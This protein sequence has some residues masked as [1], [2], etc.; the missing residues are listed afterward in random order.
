M[1]APTYLEWQDETLLGFGKDAPTA[2][3]IP[4]PSLDTA[5]E[6]GPS[7]FQ[8][9]LNGSW[10]FHWVNHPDRRPANFY[11]T[12]FNDSAWPEIRVPSNWQTEGYDV[13]VY[14]NQRYPFLCQPPLV[15]E[16]PPDHYTTFYDRNPVGSYRRTFTVPS[17][18]I[19]RRICVRFEGVD[20]FF[21][22]WINGQYVGF[23]KD[24]RTTAAFDLTPHLVEGENQI[25][26][27]VYRYSDGSYLEDQ[28]FWRLSGIYR[29]V[30]L[31]AHAPEGIRDFLIEPRLDSDLQGG[32]LNVTCEVP[33]DARLAIH[34]FDAEANLVKTGAASD[35]IAE[36]TVEAPRLWSA[37]IP[38]LYVVVL[39]LTDAAGGVI[40]CASTRCGFRRIEIQDGVFWLNNVAIKL[41]G[42]NRHEHTYRDGHA[43]SVESM[44]EDIRLMKQ[45]NINHVRTAHY[46][47]HPAWYDL[48]DEYGLYVMDE[49]NVESHGCGYEEK[50]LSHFPSWRAAH[51]ERCTNM[52]YRDRNHPCV[53]FWSLGNEAGPGENFQH[54]ADAVRALDPTRPL[55]YE[56]ANWVADIDSIMY[57]H[58]EW[59]EDEAAGPRNRP[60]YL[61]EYGHSMGNAVGNLHNYWQ[62]IESSPHMLGGCIWEWM[63]HALPARTPEGAEYPAYGG[64]FGDQPNDGLFIADGLLFYDRSPKPAY[65]ELKKVHQPIRLSWSPDHPARV[66]VCN[67]HDFTDLENF[68]IRWEMI[69][70]GKTS[71]FGEWM[72]LSLAPCES[73][74]IEF[75]LRP[76]P[77]TQDAWL[78]LRVCLREDTPWAE[79]NFEIAAEQLFFTSQKASP[80]SRRP[81][82]SPPKGKSSLQLEESLKDWLIA[83]KDF[84]V[85]IGKSAEPTFQWQVEGH[86]LMDR[87]PGLNAFR[88]PLDNDWRWIGDSWFVHGLHNLNPCIVESTVESVASDV[89]SLSTKIYWAANQGARVESAVR[90]GRVRLVSQPIPTETLRFSTLMRWQIRN[91]CTI[92]LTC[93]ITPAGLSIVLPRLGLLF[94]LPTAWDQVR[95]LGRGPWENYPDRKSAAFV[96]VNELTVKE[97]LTPYAKPQDCGSR[98]DVRWLEIFSRG[99]E[100]LHITCRTPLAA[101]ALPHSP[102]ELTVA[103]HP[104]ELPAPERTWLSLDARQLGIGG[105]S[106]GPPPHEIDWVRPDPVTLDLTM[107]PRH[108]SH[109]P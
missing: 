107:K 39:V 9:S 61:C 24:S 6:R 30:F 59:M 72:D 48:C 65:W 57:A 62:P 69:E 79:A 97:M 76:D 103:S 89:I 45:A 106:C 42:V 105:N 60:F 10:K 52:V 93:Q 34:L 46:P 2:S 14:T 63:D 94:S 33:Q 28:D 29:D 104:H 7:P 15:M 84:E 31:V 41:R 91:D 4:Y 99:G 18:W 21:Y 43:V 82:L 98:Q 44:I 1:I 3:F 101:A 88:A 86:V 83:G 81:Q 8:Q 38:Y 37:E 64:D 19:G 56:R 55:H 85:R 32:T 102:M 71:T 5:R 47:N 78:T 25:A 87:P 17:H 49:A 16:T 108:L 22:L 54:A 50:S 40:E 77:S 68:L 13:P 67:R 74:E 27:E 70:D 80:F 23:S 75:P 92:R 36:L 100:G 90:E 51:V 20:S 26:V 58:L 73:T 53:I 66:V 96:N 109:Q 12:D 35:G 95:Y 11:R